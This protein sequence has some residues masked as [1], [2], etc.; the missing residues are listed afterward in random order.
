MTGPLR[1]ASLTLDGR[2]F[3][4]PM[5]GCSELAFRRICRA[6]GA[7]LTYTELVSARG[8]RCTASLKHAFPYIAISPD[9]AP[10]AIQLFGSEPDDFRAALERIL[11][12]P[13]TRAL[14]V[15]DVNMG[16]PVR[17]V[18][19]SASGA[20]LIRDPERACAIVRALRRDLEGT[21]IACTVKTRIGFDAG[22]NCIA[23]FAVRLAS[24]GAEAICVHGR[25]RAQ[26]YSGRADWRAIRGARGALDQAGFRDLPLIAN[27]DI[28]DGASAR[29]AL[30]ESGAEA[31]MIGRAAM[32]N[33]WIFRDI[34]RYL[35]GQE[36]L[37]PPDGAERA[38][39]GRLHARYLMEQMDE[40]CVCR[41]MRKTLMHYT[42]GLRNARQLRQLASTVSTR[43]DLEQFWESVRMDGAL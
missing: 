19:R 15:L 36:A 16:C 17:K 32:G 34:R 39:I 4:A 33:P 27:G 40:A 9:I 21:G 20:A 5:A 12:D 1:I 22:E 25:T 43:E 30:D 35:D 29:A 6:F 26:M 41:E 11:L 23:D 42:Q 8:I 3:L 13:R 28:R 24:A 37:P 18:V 14:R 10:A 7:A 2:L 31:L 38:R